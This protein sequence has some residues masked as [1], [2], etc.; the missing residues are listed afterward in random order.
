MTM[1]FDGSQDDESIL[2]NMGALPDGEYK[3]CLAHA[4]K[5]WSRNNPEVGLLKCE[6][7]CLDEAYEGR[8]IFQNF[9]LKHPTSPKAV[10]IGR[11]KFKKICLAALEKPAIETPDELYGKPIVLK[12]K[13]RKQKNGQDSFELEKIYSTTEAQAMSYTPKTSSMSPDE[14]TNVF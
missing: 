2:D 4:S 13:N 14:L 5:E 7:E 12:M 1:F 6:F 11:A 10:E 8:K 9:I 3:V